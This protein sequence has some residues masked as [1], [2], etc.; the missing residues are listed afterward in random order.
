MSPRT[1][2]RIEISVAVGLVCA[3]IGIIYFASRPLA[4]MDAG[5]QTI[6]P[7]SKSDSDNKPAENKVNLNDFR[8]LWGLKLQQPLDPPPP[9]ETI[10]SKQEPI[11]QPPP[12]PPPPNVTLVN[13]FFSNNAR[14]AVF[15]LPG[16]S[17]FVRCFEGDKVGNAEVTTITADEVELGIGEH[18]YSYKTK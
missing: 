10:I 16:K 6:Q 7:A 1:K 18:R 15:K 13:I 12:K 17:E 11:S 3:S 5:L 9:A 14:M 8:A 2:H 4:D